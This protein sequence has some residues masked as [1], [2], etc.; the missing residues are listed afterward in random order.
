MGGSPSRVSMHRKIAKKYMSRIL[1]DH[2]QKAVSEARLDLSKLESMTERAVR[3]I[4]DS[5]H[6]DHIYKESGDM[7]FLYQ[8]TLESL[9]DHLSTLSYIVDKV[10]LT[11]AAN[12]LNPSL[13][14][15][16]DKAFKESK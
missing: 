1:S 2:L 4:D 12:D 7:V 3:L 16:L 11:G 13:R 15:Q 14:E 8:T 10:A 5:D 9:R 6:K